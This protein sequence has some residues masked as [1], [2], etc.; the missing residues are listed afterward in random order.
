MSV[1]EQRYTPLLTRNFWDLGV[2]TNRSDNEMKAIL[3]HIG[4]TIETDGSITEDVY[5]T[6]L[7]IY[8]EFQSHR[9]FVSSSTIIDHSNTGDRYVEK[10]I[11]KVLCKDCEQCKYK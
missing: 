8:I 7:I 11:L 4:Q 5:T 6:D 1:A 3:I 9:T 2:V 10:P